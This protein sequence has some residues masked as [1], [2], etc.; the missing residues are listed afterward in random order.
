MRQWGGFGP[1]DGQFLSPFDVAVGPAGDV[2]VVDDRRGDIQGFAAD[3]TWLTTIGS[4]GTGE[5]QLNDT[6]GIDVDAS[7]SIL[8]ADF[9]NH[10]V[11]AWGPTGDYLWSHPMATDGGSVNRWTSLRLPTA[12]STSRMGPA[13]TSSTPTVRR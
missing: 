2:F 6:G 13:S 12:P 4:Y 3:G 5:G 1:A 10:R 11:Q 9:D 7:G 8:N